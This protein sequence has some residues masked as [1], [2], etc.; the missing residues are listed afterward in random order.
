MQSQCISDPLEFEA[1]DG[2]RPAAGFAGDRQGNSP[3]TPRRLNGIVF[4]RHAIVAKAA[5]MATISAS[6]NAR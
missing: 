6:L 5:E 3:S 2:R 1:F 4:S